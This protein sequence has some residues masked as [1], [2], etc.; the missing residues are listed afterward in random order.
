MS[1]V[2]LRLRIRANRGRAWSIHAKGGASRY[3]GGM[4]TASPARFGERS[5]VALLATRVQG[6]YK[7]ISLA[8]KAYEMSKLPR[9]HVLGLNQ[10]W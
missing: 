4:V 5:Y 8:E 2:R 1:R 3:R 9:T 6:A 10:E 7:D